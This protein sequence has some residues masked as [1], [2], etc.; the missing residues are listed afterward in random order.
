MAL[1]LPLLVLIL[2]GGMEAGYFLWS[3]HKVVKGVRDGARFAGRQGFGIVNCTSGTFDDAAVITAIKN[4]TR[5]GTADASND[6]TVPGWTDNSTQVTIS[7]T[8]DATTKTGIYEAEPIDGAPLVT[9]SATVPYPSLFGYIAFDLSGI[10]LNAKAE[11]A[12]MGA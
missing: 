10:K 11:A 8:C 2:F 12:V 4:V 1:M 3:E 6:P 9:V 7:I 5:T